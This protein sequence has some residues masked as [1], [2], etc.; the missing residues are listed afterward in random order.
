MGK[1]KTNVGIRE[2]TQI[3]DTKGQV[4]SDTKVIQQELLAFW[5]NLYT[6]KTNC[7]GLAPQYLQNLPQIS[8]ETYLKLEQPLTEVELNT[9]LMSMT[10]GK[11]P[12]QDG[13]TVAF[14][15]TFWEFL[16]IPFSLLTQAL[17][18]TECPQIMNTGILRLLPKPRK[19]LLDVKSWRPICLQG[20]D[21]K[22][23]VKHLQKSYNTLYRR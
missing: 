7:M 13:L 3:K 20:V 17:Y 18:V 6:K 19:D 14:Y 4:V 16:K 8:K 5:G 12:G 23:V 21:I 10:T 2:I 11:S 1:E 22:V 9:L 15:Q